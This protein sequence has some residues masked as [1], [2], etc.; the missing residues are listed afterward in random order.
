MESA[1]AEKGEVSPYDFEG[2]SPRVQAAV[3]E[4]IDMVSDRVF[5]ERFTLNGVFNLNFFSIK[6]E[7]LA[8]YKAYTRLAIRQL[9]MGDFFGPEEPPREEEVLIKEIAERPLEREYG[10]LARLNNFGASLLHDI[11]HTWVDLAQS[12]EKTL[13][14]LVPKFLRYKKRIRDG[15]VEAQASSQDES[16]VSFYNIDGGF[17]TRGGILKSIRKAKNREEFLSHDYLQKKKIPDAEISPFRQYVRGRIFDEYKT[18]PRLLWEVFLSETLPLMREFAPKEV[19]A[20]RK[21][22][23][24]S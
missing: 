2:L 13:P 3:Q 11:T 20:L 14:A 21:Q 12:R 6:D 17:R 5:V 24:G 22:Y 18:N 10:H 19:M 4:R 9:V 8:Y 23:G 1:R 7:E 16:V 15:G